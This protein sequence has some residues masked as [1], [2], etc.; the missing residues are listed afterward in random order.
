MVIGLILT[1]AGHKDLGVALVVLAVLFNL[2]L[3]FRSSR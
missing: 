1:F 3:L 2:P